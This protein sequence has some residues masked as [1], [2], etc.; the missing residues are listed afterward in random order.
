MFESD[1][2]DR[3]TQ[4]AFSGSKISL[5]CLVLT[6][7]TKYRKQATWSHEQGIPDESYLVRRQKSSVS[8]CIALAYLERETLRG[9]T[10]PIS[11]AMVQGMLVL[12]SAGSV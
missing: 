8:K 7:T 4:R 9:P 6:L 1:L 2:F 12:C 5:S 3:A 11:S 10:Y